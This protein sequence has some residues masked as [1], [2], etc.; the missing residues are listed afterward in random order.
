MS[1][2]EL[3]IPACSILSRPIKIS[4][5]Q[6]R[7]AIT[8]HFSG[9]TA[10]TFQN[11]FELAQHNPSDALEPLKTFAENHPGTPIVFNLLAYCHIQLKNLKETEAII[12]TTYSQ[13]PDYLFAKVNYADL[14]LRKKRSDEILQVFNGMLDLSLL[15]PKRDTFHFS[16]V[17]GFMAVL[18]HYYHQ[19]R[20]RSKALEAFRIAVQADPTHPSLQVLEKTL[21]HNP[22]L[23]LLN[24]YLPTFSKLRRLFPI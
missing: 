13:F 11:I 24:Y 23:R 22:L 20:C 12:Q 21:F 10:T 3:T 9:K 5:E 4:F 15:D 14:L 7:S 17:R 6:D 2:K 1:N 16:E 8:H 19:T 18:G